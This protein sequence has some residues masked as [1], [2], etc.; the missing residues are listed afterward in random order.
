MTDQD[1]ITELRQLLIT[2]QQEQLKIS[3]SLLAAQKAHAEAVEASL[4]LNRKFVVSDSRIAGDC[5]WTE[6]LRAV[7][8]GCGVV[9]GDYY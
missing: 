4:R 5:R 6:S 7:A 8:Q 9:A 2:S 1:P 3:R